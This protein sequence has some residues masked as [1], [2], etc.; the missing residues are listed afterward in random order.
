MLV[1]RGHQLG[2]YAQSAG[3]PKPQLDE[4]VQRVTG[5]EVF[6]AYREGQLLLGAPHDPAQGALAFE[7]DDVV[8]ATGRR[9]CP[10]VIPNMW[11]PGV[12]DARTALIM[13]HEQAVAPGARV[14]V[15]GNGDQTAHA[16]RLRELG[17][18]V[19]AVKAISELRRVLGRNAVSAALFEQP[20]ACDALV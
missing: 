11:L 9:A 7:A 2:R 16:N 19:V 18:N 8:L 14:V 10:P 15:V 1:T 12:M 20:V 4:R 5:V 3:Q 17:V 6:G 13:A